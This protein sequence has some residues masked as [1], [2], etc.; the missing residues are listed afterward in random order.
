MKN[1]PLGIQTFSKLINGNYLYVDKTKSIYDL[2]SSGGE[3]YFLSRPRRFGK[4]LLVSTLAELFSGNKE[5]FKDLWIY[6]KIEWTPYPVIHID[7][8]KIDFE[9]PGKLKES[10]KSFLNKTARSVGLKLDK[11]NSYKESFIEL[12]EKLSV[13]GKVVILIDEYDKPVIEFL[14]KGKIDTA[15][16]IRDVLKS[17]Y[18]VLKGSDFYLKFVFITGV[19]KFSRISIFSDLNNLTDIT[20]SE[21]FST[22]LGYTEAEMHHYFSFY[23]EK[24]SKKQKMPVPDLIEKI[25][26][27][28][29]GYSW[30]GVNF[31]YNPFSILHTFNACNFKNFWFST[32]TPGFLLQL[33]KNRKSEIMNFENFPVKSYTFDTYDLEHLD[34]AALLFQTGY[35]TI[36]KITQGDEDETYHLSYPN[37]EVRVS[38]L[39]HLF[40]DFIRQ[41]MS[42]STQALDRIS[43]TIKTENIELFIQEIKSLFAS[44]PY[45]I[46]IDEK[47]AYYHTVVY[48]ILRLSGGVVQSEVSTNTGRIDAVL[49]TANHIYI[50][51]FKVGTA[52]EGLTQIKTMKYYE[53]YQGSGKKIILVGVGFDP[54][55]RNIGDYLAVEL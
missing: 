31:V 55:I 33:L 46:F 3:Y 16:E 51:E 39:S 34:I 15:K 11:D 41:D 44:I 12:I 43:K 22:L 19:S 36:K 32:G 49:E 24:M 35:L 20:L 4:S 6:D 47:E 17:F 37:R 13:K 30:D 10:L 38:F 28:Y 21:E 50:M 18:G 14:E 26:H 5:L 42:L 29:N 9:T 54:G 23:I 27:W 53:P 2:I 48:L 1:L 40:G 25:R 45:Q 52:Q 8:S 7:F